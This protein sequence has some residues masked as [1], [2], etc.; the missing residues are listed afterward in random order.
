MGGYISIT[1]LRFVIAKCNTLSR[2]SQYFKV[3]TAVT[4]Q[5]IQ[6]NLYNFIT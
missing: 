1:Y 2:V 6:P 5:R 3:M 4:V